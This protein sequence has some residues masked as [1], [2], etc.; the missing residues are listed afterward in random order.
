MV[1]LRSGYLKGGQAP[2]AQGDRIQP[3]LVSGGLTTWFSLPYVEPA[4]N[5]GVQLLASYFV[6]DGQTGFVKQIKACPFKPSVLHSSVNNQL[7][8]GVSGLSLS[9]NNPDSDDGFWRTPFGWE[10]YLSPFPEEIGPTWRW[11]LRFIS[12]DIARVREGLNIPPFSFADPLSWFLVPNLPVPASG[13]PE[14]I[15]GSSPGDGWGPQRIQ[16]F[17]M[18]DGEVHIPVPSNTTVALFAEWTQ[19]FYQPI[20]QATDGAGLTVL[21]Q[22]VF[23]LSPSFGQLE[24]YTQPNNSKITQA[25]ALDGWQS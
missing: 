6:P 23:A 8:P 13:Y 16:R 7:V 9:G 17:G 19:E 1:P 24:G 18:E 25:H 10:G 11:Q 3:W 20:F 12:G 22:Q 5:A 15:P 4:E 14:G 2:T 21:P